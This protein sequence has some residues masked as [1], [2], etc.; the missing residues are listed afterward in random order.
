MKYS[1]TIEDPNMVHTASLKNQGSHLYIYIYIYR[2]APV[3]IPPAVKTVPL[4]W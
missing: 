4:T 3:G 1:N 2:R